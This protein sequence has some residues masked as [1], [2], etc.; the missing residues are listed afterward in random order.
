MAIS[1][2]RPT[3]RILPAVC[4]VVV[5][6]LTRCSE[7]PP[8][9]ST[10]ATLPAGFVSVGS[11]DGL[12]VKAVKERAR[13]GDRVTIVGRIGGSV[14]P[15]VADR[16]VFTIVDPALPSC[17]DG[18]DSDHCATPYDYCCE[19]R[20]NLRSATA[21]IEIVDVAGEP[22]PIG[23]R[24]VQ[25]L[26]PLVTIAVTGLVADRNDQGLLIVRAERIERRKTAE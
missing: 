2:T 25:G 10:G 7:A 14:Q 16:A 23:L 8:T 24:G 20:S 9:P 22:L 6:A 15:F 19:D 13:T 11:A 1:H 18:G 17:A 5:A 12:A 3:L 4:L 26:D 21:T